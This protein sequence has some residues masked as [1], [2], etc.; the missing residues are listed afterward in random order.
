M[1]PLGSLFSSLMA[2]ADFATASDGDG[3][4]KRIQICTSIIV[5]DLVLAMRIAFVVTFCS[6]TPLKCY[7]GCLFITLSDF[8]LCLKR[9]RNPLDFDQ[10]WRSYSASFFLVL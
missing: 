3:T 2:N 8:S 4:I 10:M 5:Y 1:V 6:R 9:Y 7:F